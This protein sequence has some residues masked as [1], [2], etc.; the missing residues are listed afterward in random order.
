MFIYTLENKKTGKWKTL[1]SKL[2]VTEWA[3]FLKGYNM[4]PAEWK[5]WD[6]ID[7]ENS[8]D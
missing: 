4:N 8:W 1:Y 7:T 2:D 6:T 3:D 5:L